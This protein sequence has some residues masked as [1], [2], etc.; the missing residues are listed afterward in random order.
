MGLSRFDFTSAIH[1]HPFFLMA[2]Y[3]PGFLSSHFPG[4]QIW[5][6]NLDKAPVLPARPCLWQ[7]ITPSLLLKPRAA[8][9]LF[10]P[11]RPGYSPR[12]SEPSLEHVCPAVLHAH[13]LISQCHAL[14]FTACCF[15]DHFLPRTNGTIQISEIG[16]YWEQSV[17]IDIPD[18]TWDICA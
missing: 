2:V 6:L 14:I 13:S 1:K 10:Y 16:F 17:L 15:W 18:C 4:L 3:S 7:C 11:Q 9:H 5:A 12:L 8:L